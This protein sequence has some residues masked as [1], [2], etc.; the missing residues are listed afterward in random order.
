MII[1]TLHGW[2]GDAIRMIGTLLLRAIEIAVGYVS[3][4]VSKAAQY[5]FY[6]VVVWNL[7]YKNAAYI[8][9]TWPDSNYPKVNID[10]NKNILS[11]T[12]RL[13]HEVHLLSNILH[14][15]QFLITS[16]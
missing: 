2:C 1:V 10:E 9:I 3:R 13:M 7:G 11:T 16:L 8:I 4:K 6:T 12:E 14:K 15:D 5:V